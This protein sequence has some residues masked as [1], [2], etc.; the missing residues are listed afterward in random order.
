MSLRSIL[1]LSLASVALCATAPGWTPLQGPKTAQ[2]VVYRILNTPK[3]Y[4]IEFQN[5][6]STTVHFAFRFLPYQTKDQAVENGRIN[7]SPGT[8]KAQ[9]RF[10]VLSAVLPV[11]LASAPVEAYNVRSGSIDK[12]RFDQ[13]AP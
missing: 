12:G 3:G 10:P 11:A 7:L 4:V 5:T 8:H 6:G 13:E 2:V 9:I 1:T